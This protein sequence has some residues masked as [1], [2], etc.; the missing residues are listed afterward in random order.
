MGLSRDVTMGEDL[1]TNCVVRGNGAVDIVTG[2]VASLRVT[3][4][5]ANSVTTSYNVTCNTV[6]GLVPFISLHFCSFST[7]ASCNDS[8]RFHYIGEGPYLGLLYLLL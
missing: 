1:T 3:R 8:K 5:T 6:S 2:E 7:R 4:V